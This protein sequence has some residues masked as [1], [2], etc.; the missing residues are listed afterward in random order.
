MGTYWT[1]SASNKMPKYAG[2]YVWTNMLTGEQ[3][4]G[5]SVELAKRVANYK[6]SKIFLK[7]K[8]VLLSL[9]CLN[10]E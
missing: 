8:H 10:M 2:I 3:Y 7:K 1:C 5:S 6:Q 9:I 4:V